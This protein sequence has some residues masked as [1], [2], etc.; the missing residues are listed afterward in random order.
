MSNFLPRPWTADEARTDTSWVQRLS[1]EAVQDLDAALAHAEGL[2]KP[3][4]DMVA[5]DFPI[6]GAALSALQSA[7]TAT[8]GRWGMCLLKG[9]PVHRWTSEQVR[10]AYWGMGLHM[11]VARTQNPKSQ[12]INDVRDEGAVYKGKNG[13]GYNTN[14]GLDF[15]MDSCDVVALLCRRTALEGG[16]SMVASTM[17]VAQELRRRR[18]DLYRVLQQPFHHHY[19]GAQHPDQPPYYQCPIIGSDDLPFTMRVNRKNIVAA[20]NDF[21]EVPRVTPQQWEALDLLE[22]LMADPLYCFRMHLEE[23]DLQL[24]NNYVI[25]HSRTAFVDH[26]APDRKRHLLRL[27]LA[28][29]DSQPLPPD[30]AEYFIDVRAGSLRGGL[31]GSEITPAFEAFELRQAAAMGMEHRPWAPLK[32][33]H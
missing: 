18:P 17:A 28:V 7:M 14:A 19:Q 33:R 20:Q 8:Q 21:P 6:R 29:P 13:R 30:W 24:V 9:F 22:G 10:L 4:L 26:E 1:D 16:Q 2:R 31:R 5:E 25:V 23:G 15:H 27:W 12:T 32:R 3:L 11:G